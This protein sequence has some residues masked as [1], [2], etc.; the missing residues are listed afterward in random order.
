M[1]PTPLIGVVKDIPAGYNSILSIN[2]YYDQ[3]TVFLIGVQYSKV[4]SSF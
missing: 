2:F 4:Q 3:H 1:C